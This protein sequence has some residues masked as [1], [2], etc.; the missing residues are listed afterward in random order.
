MDITQF[1]DISGCVLQIM[2]VTSYFTIALKLVYRHPQVSSVISHDIH[3]WI[4][5]NVKCCV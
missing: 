5:Q 1:H 2:H 3:K 4:L